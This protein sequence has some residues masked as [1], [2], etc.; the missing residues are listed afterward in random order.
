VPGDRCIL[1]GSSKLPPA[2]AATFDLGSGQLRL[3]RYWRLP[4]APEQVQEKHDNDLVEEFQHLLQDSVRRQLVA[5]VPVG[6]LLS[7]GVDSSLVTAV[8]AR[9]GRSVKTFTIRFPDYGS[10]DET[11]YARL[12]ANH[13]STE[14]IELVA[15]PSTVDLL[16]ELARQ[17]DEPIVDSSMIPTYLVCRLVRQHFKVALGGDGGDELFGG[18]DHY[19][20]LLRMQR[21]I[22]WVPTPLRAAVAG[23]ARTLLPVGL[24]G[25]NYIMG[26]DIDFHRGTP[27]MARLFDRTARQRL[28]HGDVNRAVEGTPLPEDCLDGYSSNGTDVLDRTQRTDFQFYLPEDILV[29]VDRTAMVNS[30]ETRAPFLDYRIVEFAFSKVPSR[31]KVDHYRKKILAK[32]LGKRL[33]PANFDW[34]RK[35]GFSIPLTL[36]LR[37]E[38]RASFRTLLLDGTCSLFNRVEIERIWNHHQRGFSNS[39]RLFALGLFQLWR[40]KYQVSW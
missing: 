14:H 35:Q 36:W 32:M 28:L 23:L 7:G 8:A 19:T 26:L 38:W 10:Y 30:L 17:F 27:N 22:G 15:E 18:Y 29:K 2:H 24:R 9:S 39:E 11:P 34:E 5:D 1:E 16:P 31:L 40:N 13:F 21:M 25:R 37:N 4:D 33:L 3:W 20:R 12:I 6:I